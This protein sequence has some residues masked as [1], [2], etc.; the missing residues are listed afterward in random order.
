M[1]TVVI[2]RHGNTFDKGDI[3]TRVGGLTDLSLSKSGQEQA[4][5]LA[6]YFDQNGP[7]FDRAYSSDLKRTVGTLAPILNRSSHATDS[8]ETLEF[9]REVDYGPDENKPEAEV[10]A[11]IGQEAL[12]LWET[13][14]QLPQGWNLDTTALISSWD[15]FFKHQAKLGGASLV[16]TSNGIARFIFQ[17]LQIPS[18]DYSIKLRTGAFGVLQQGHGGWSL[19]A[20]DRR[21]TSP[22]V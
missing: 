8:I 11:R 19:Q 1:N 15:Q 2:C 13:K 5:R 12:A 22:T 14:A 17:A 10:I 9:L 7:F 18:E 3:V 6:D 21:P 20:W 16:M 4:Q